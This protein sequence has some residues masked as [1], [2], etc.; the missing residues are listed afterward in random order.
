MPAKKRNAVVYKL[1]DR[2]KIVYIGETVNPENREQKH[3]SDGKKFTTMSIESRRMTKE[4]AKEK[5]T[6][7]L[8]KYR[9]NHGGNNPKYNKDSDG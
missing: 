9:K 7:M 6:E 8:E 5:E 3:I 2:N 4:G 1:K